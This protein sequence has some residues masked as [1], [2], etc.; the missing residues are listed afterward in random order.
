MKD[1]DLKLL[2]FLGIF[3][4][5][6]ISSLL[7]FQYDTIT[8][9]VIFKSNILS[10]KIDNKVNPNDLVN[11]YINTQLV[12]S[13]TCSKGGKCID[14]LTISQ[15]R[16]YIIIEGDINKI[17]SLKNL[18]TQEPFKSIA[19]KSG[20]YIITGPGTKLRDLV[21]AEAQMW[22]T[23]G[24]L[25][26][27]AGEIGKAAGSTK[28]CR[29]QKNSKLNSYKSPNII[30]PSVKDKAIT[31]I[32]SRMSGR[33][34]GDAVTVGA[35]CNGESCMI[36]NP[37]YDSNRKPTGSYSIS[38]SHR[39]SQPLD[40][41]SQFN[42]N[43][44]VIK[45]S[46]TYTIS[47]YDAQGNPVQKDCHHCNI[48]SEGNSVSEGSKKMLGEN[49]ECVAGCNGGD[50]AVQFN[51]EGI[52]SC[53][54]DCNLD[55]KDAAKL[56]DQEC[57][58]TSKTKGVT[59]MFPGIKWASI[60]NPPKPGD[61][62]RVN[63]D[64]VIIPKEDGGRGKIVMPSVRPDRDN[65]DPKNGGILSKDECAKGVILNPAEK[66]INQVAMDLIK[67]VDPMFHQA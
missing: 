20:T 59:T 43:M 9:N 27:F 50:Y 64:F 37:E 12:N 39:Q 48:N 11:N 41:T 30:N 54:G 63:A 53:S 21:G 5:L 18:K 31:M 33:S 40:V 49:G 34:S 16:K 57:T 22:I 32:N 44:E 38:F 8:G 29:D 19:G 52:D 42:G 4:L 47:Y 58:Y 62:V 3:S 56:C 23:I 55:D 51:E 14:G 28:G 46:D 36:I 7:V 66:I 2:K 10:N 1:G 13:G 15:H 61:K 67:D 45:N 24:S 17:N 65:Y 25:S 35:A 6:L 26:N 60:I